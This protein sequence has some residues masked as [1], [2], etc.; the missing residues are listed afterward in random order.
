MPTLAAIL[1]NVISV[2]AAL[3][4][5]VLLLASGANAKPEAILQIKWMTIGIGVLT[6]ATVAISAWLVT[7]QRAWHA[8]GVGL[9]PTLVIVVLLIVLVKLEW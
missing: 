8:A 2:V 9:A 5:I 3:G 7:H 6:L 1:S 4:M